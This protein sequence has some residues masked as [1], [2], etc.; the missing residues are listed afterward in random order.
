MAKT[1]W[2][3]FL[4]KLKISTNLHNS[5]RQSTEW[6]SIWL[7]LGCGSAFIFCSLGIR[8]KLLSQCGSGSTLKTLQKI[9]SEEL[10]AVKKTCLK[11]FLKIMELVQIRHTF[12]IKIITFTDFLAFILLLFFNFPLLDSEPEGKMYADPY[13]Q[14]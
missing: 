11:S 1:I 3:K 2:V 7:P 12:F 6:S 8:I 4:P 14:P 5:W 10:T 9:P 13:P